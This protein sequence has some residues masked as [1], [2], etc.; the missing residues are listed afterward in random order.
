MP[1]ATIVK[2]PYA[3]LYY[4]LDWFPWLETGDTLTASTWTVPAALTVLDSGFV[5]SGTEQYTYVKLSG[6]TLAEKHEVVNK[7]TTSAGL[8]EQ[9]TLEF[10][11]E[12]R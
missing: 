12:K 8:K 4:F 9:A 10:T 2:S 1:L 5:N 3:E 11:I 6:G 7:I